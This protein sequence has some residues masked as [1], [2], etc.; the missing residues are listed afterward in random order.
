MEKSS[1]FL[2]I[3]IDRHN[4]PQLDIGNEELKKYDIEKVLRSVLRILFVQ[5]LNA[6][7][8]CSLNSAVSLREDMQ[9]RQMHW[10]PDNGSHKSV[11][12]ATLTPHLAV[13]DP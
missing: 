12:P 10:M 2:C 8:Q 6:A 5:Q 3:P 9:T 7:A 4:L 11:H 1:G 13:Y